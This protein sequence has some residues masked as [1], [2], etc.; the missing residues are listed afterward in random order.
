MPEQ[1][2]RRGRA[3]EPLQGDASPWSSRLFDQTRMTAS[4][5]GFGSTGS[6]SHAHRRPPRGHP[7]AARRPRESH[8]QSGLHPD[9]WGSGAEDAPSRACQ[10]GA[11][12]ARCRPGPE[13][14]SRR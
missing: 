10:P 7:I 12:K 4:S 9:K 13:K 6:V 5:V 2:Q 3:G 8:T 14:T 1:Q 11:G